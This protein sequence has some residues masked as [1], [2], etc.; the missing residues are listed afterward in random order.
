L[1]GWNTEDGDERSGRGDDNRECDE[2][3]DAAIPIGADAVLDVLIH[4]STNLCEPRQRCYRQ[5]GPAVARATP[6]T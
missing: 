1:R 3:A 4:R 5:T 6:S 2:H